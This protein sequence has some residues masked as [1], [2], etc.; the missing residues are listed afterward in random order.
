MLG[1]G[2]RMHHQLCYLA[3]TLNI[4][5]HAAIQREATSECRLRAE[6]QQPHRDGKGGD[7]QPAG[8]AQA[9]AQHRAQLCHA[10]RVGRGGIVAAP[11]R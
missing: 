11:E 7:W 6:L 10:H 4:A 5:A 3:A 8:P 2:K 1:M 9:T